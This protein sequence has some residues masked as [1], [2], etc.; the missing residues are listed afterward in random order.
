MKLIVGLGNPGRTYA[1][2]RHNIGFMVIDELAS[3]YGISM[4]KR[5]F[6]AK[7]GKGSIS[8]V[9]VLLAK[10]QTYMNRSGYSVGPLIGFYKCA[11]EDLIVVH[12]DI[13][14]ALGKIKIAKGAGHGGH[15]GIKSIMEEIPNIAFLRV[16]VGVGRP[17]EYMDAADYVL[18]AFS[19]EEKDIKEDL[20]VRA[21]NAVEDL[22][23]YKLIEVQQ[24]YH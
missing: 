5:A 13:D 21:T 8:D 7:V 15:N 10:P 9:D 20:I 17:P 6:D 16:R 22:L 14:I 23:K 4:R 2:H 18:Q 19:K 12:D 3:R 1:K 11:A 24:K